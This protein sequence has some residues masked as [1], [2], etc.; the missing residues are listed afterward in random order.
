[1]DFVRVVPCRFLVWHLW[2]GC[3]TGG[4]VALM[5]RWIYALLWM[6]GGVLFRDASAFSRVWTALEAFTGHLDLA[7]D[8][9]KTR[10]WSTSSRSF[11]QGQVEVL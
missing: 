10:L 7:I 3:L 5:S 4:S 2:I 8:M 1:M 9:S 11:R 6:T